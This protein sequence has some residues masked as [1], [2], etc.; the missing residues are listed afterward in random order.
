MTTRIGIRELKNRA[1]EI[2]RE[3]QE[4]QAEFIVTLRGAPVAVLRPLSS[5]GDE[6]ESVRTRREIALE[7]LDALAKEITDSWR[8]TESVVQLIEAQRR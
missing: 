1:S 4:N 8:S 2:V 6:Q 5:S 3:V 7:K